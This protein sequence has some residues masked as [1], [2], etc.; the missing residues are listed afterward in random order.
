MSEPV[1]CFDNRQYHRSVSNHSDENSEQYSQHR[2][3]WTKTVAS[4]NLV[5]VNTL[6][7]IMRERGTANP[8]ARFLTRHVVPNSIYKH[9]PSS[10]EIH[11]VGVERQDSHRR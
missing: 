3:E 5:L 9:P 10:Y 1:P 11:P 2:I 7:L 4:T 6:I 8:G